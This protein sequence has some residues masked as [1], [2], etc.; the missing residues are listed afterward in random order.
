M[1]KIIAVCKENKIP[2]VASFAYEN[3]EDD[4]VGCC[5]TN[6]YFD[7]RKHDNF[8]EANK[9]IRSSGITSMA[10]TIKSD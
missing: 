5:T 7:N 9:A 6:L 10:L 3:N 1:Q 8:I 4:G 2:M